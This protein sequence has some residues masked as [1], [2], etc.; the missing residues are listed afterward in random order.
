MVNRSAQFIVERLLQDVVLIEITGKQR[1]RVYRAQ[2]VLNI[3]E[4]EQEPLTDNRQDR[5]IQTIT[6][7]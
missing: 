3:L 7:S 2:G 4:M 6:E 1:G 5:I